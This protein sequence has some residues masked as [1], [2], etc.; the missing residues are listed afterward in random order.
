MP[1]WCNNSVTIRHADPAKI[2]ELNLAV[3][4]GNFCK[5]VKP[6]PE[7]LQNTQAPNSSENAGAL[8]EKYGYADWYDFCVNE[9]GTKW[10]VDPE[11]VDSPDEKT[12]TFYFDSAWSPPTGIYEQLVADGYEVS[13]Y[14]HEPG[15]CFVGF[16]YDGEDECYDYS[17]ETSETVREVIGEELDDMFNI[18][19]E[20]ESYE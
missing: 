6:I 8:A 13:A 9:W 14:Y 5:T 4:D 15:M 7:E 18:S 11:N 1:N 2:K 17:G 16:W 10:D 3:R 19:E 20:L 12:L